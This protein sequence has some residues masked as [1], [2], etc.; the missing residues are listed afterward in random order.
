MRHPYFAGNADPLKFRV[1]SEGV[2]VVV[3]NQTLQVRF[4]A[5]VLSEFLDYK[6]TYDWLNDMLI[7]RLAY[8]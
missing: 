1:I 2:K 7:R 5:K 6:L 8:G 4:E 3:R